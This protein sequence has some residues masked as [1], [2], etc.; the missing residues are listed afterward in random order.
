MRLLDRIHVRLDGYT[1]KTKRIALWTIGLVLLLLASFLVSLLLEPRTPRLKESDKKIEA[2]LMNP[3]APDAT[4]E[5][6]LAQIAGLKSQIAQVQNAQTQLVSQ[7]N[8]RGAELTAR[9]NELSSGDKFNDVIVRRIESSAQNAVDSAI[10]QGRITATSPSVPKGGAS[11]TVPA[12]M[13]ISPT[14]VDL[15]APLPVPGQPNDPNSSANTVATPGPSLRMVESETALKKH[16]TSAGS[17]KNSASGAG[18]SGTSGTAGAGE[19][20]NR[21]A[22]PKG[23]ETA[24]ASARDQR[25]GK[26]AQDPGVFIPAGTILRGVLLSGMDTPTAGAALKQPTPALVRVKKEAILPNNFRADLR[27][28]FILVSGYGLMSSE[29]AYLRTELLTCVRDDGGAV[30][31]ALNGYAVGEDGKAG[32]RGRPVTKQG[33][34]MAKALVAGV[35]SGIGKALQPTA[36]LPTNSGATSGALGTQVADLTTVLESGGASGVSSALNQVAKFYLDAAKEMFPVIEIDAG[37]GI[38]IIITKGTQIKFGG[39]SH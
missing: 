19:S 8:T 15:N 11:T 36:I 25:D 38:E 13:A 20:G 34:I 6:L 29:R 24:N 37:R 23:T 33:A 22:A 32:L 14:V 7:L 27:E 30:E 10:R 35:L 18:G 4:N 3:A 1:P 26:P 39:K 2:T 12:G 16:D 9:V 17:S 21:G 28:C 5:A 31:V